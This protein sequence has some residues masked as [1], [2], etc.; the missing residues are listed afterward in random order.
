[1]ITKLEYL[2]FTIIETLQMVWICY[3]RWKN[4][5]RRKFFIGFFAPVAYK[6][7]GSNIS[8]QNLV[9]PMITKL[10]YLILQS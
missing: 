6:L 3:I 10:E 9:Y 4:G 2:L 1:M 5:K 7:Y 8:D